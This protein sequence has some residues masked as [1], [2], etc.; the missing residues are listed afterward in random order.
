MKSFR[1]RVLSAI[2]AV[3]VVVLLTYFWGNLGLKALCYMVP[4]IGV[5]ELQKILFRDY[6]SR[7]LKFLFTAFVFIIFLL[8]VWKQ[9]YVLIGFCSVA[10]IYFSIAIFLE[11]K[12]LDLE[13]LMVFQAKSLMGFFYLGLLPATAC[14][15]LDLKEGR[16]WF[17]SLLLIVLSGDTFAYFFGKIWGKKKIMPAISPNKTFIGAAGG[18]LGSALAAIC[19]GILFLSQFPLYLIIALSL[20]T[21]AISQLG[22]FFESLLKRVAN[23]KDSGHIMPGHGGILDRV[24]GLLF[25]APILFL[26]ASLIETFFS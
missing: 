23:V 9:A 17:F 26:G 13:E 2:V 11:K 3:S 1:T 21:G 19:M 12:F 5:I 7:L 6:E 4:I 24:D 22:D 10:V 20:V 18:L 25:G 14:L 16:I 8:S 15:I